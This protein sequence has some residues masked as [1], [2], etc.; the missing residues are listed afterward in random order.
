ME[1]IN[2]IPPADIIKCRCCKTIVTNNDVFCPNCA[3]PLQ[4]TDDEQST[5]IGQFIARKNEQ[6][7]WKRQV[8]SATTTLIVVAILTIVG[9]AIS[10]MV[11]RE[12]GGETIFIIS[13]V[14]AAIYFFLA[15]WSKKNPFGAIL[16]GLIIYV[17]LHLLYA[18]IDPTSIIK[19]IIIKVIVISYMIKGIV[20]AA[21]VRNVS[22]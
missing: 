4:G 12:L 18:F 7:E 15:W 21:K 1:E 20:G 10:A 9:G 6:E 16:T 14:L 2:P 13:L 19:G 11:N 3:Y 8:S 22:H 5:F 17:S